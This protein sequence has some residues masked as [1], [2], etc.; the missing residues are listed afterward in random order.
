MAKSNVMIDNDRVRVTEWSFE[1]GDETGHHVHEFDYV[2]V[3]MLNGQLK[4]VDDEG[5]E[6]ISSL[7]EGNSYFRNKGVSHNVLNNNDF[8]YKFIEVEIK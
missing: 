7:T 4:I 3:P 6:S 5:N 8:P 2:V 1:I